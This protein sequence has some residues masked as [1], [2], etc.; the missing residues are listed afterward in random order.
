M[1]IRMVYGSRLKIRGRGGI[2]IISWGAS[3]IR[4]FLPNEGEIPIYSG[5]AI[6]QGVSNNIIEE[7]PSSDRRLIMPYHISGRFSLPIDISVDNMQSVLDQSEGWVGKLLLRTVWIYHRIY[8]FLFP[9]TVEV[10]EHARI[11]ASERDYQVHPPEASFK[12]YE[13]VLII[14]KNMQTH[15]PM[16]VAFE[17]DMPNSLPV[18]RDWTEDMGWSGR[19]EDLT[20][21]WLH[22]T[23]RKSC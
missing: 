8:R 5:D 3:T 15:L 2:P 11:E 9:A 20:K 19:C 12:S 18:Y 14:P 13:K 4:V 10:V 6:P 7:E 17:S 21:Q 22:S 1:A 16:I 23:G